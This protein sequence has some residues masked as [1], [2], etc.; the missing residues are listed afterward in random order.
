ML[1]MHNNTQHVLT[2]KE[3]HFLMILSHTKRSS[4]EE[5]NALWKDK[6]PTSNAIRSFIKHLRKKLPDNVLKN[7]NG[8]GYI[9]QS[10]L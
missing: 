1:V 2:D 8:F 4:Y 6:I 3:L 5:I 7:K 9:L 10:T